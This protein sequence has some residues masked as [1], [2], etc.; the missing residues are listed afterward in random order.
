MSQIR[1]LKEPGYIYD[2]LFIFYLRFN[3]QYY[4]NML[5]NFLTTFWKNFLTFRMIYM[6]FFMPLKTDAVFLQHNILIHIK[7]SSRQ[8]ITLN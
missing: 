5:E 4:I 2:L 1:L 7:N 3:K 6:F 8:P